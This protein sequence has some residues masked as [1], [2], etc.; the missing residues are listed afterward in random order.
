[1][2]T[3]P[4][5]AGAAPRR[6][7]PGSSREHEIAWRLWPGPWMAGACP[8][9]RCAARPPWPPRPWRSPPPP[10][11]RRRRGGARHHRAPARRHAPP[12]RPLPGLPGYSAGIDPSRL[13]SSG[14][15]QRFPFS[16]GRCREGGLVGRFHRPGGRDARDRGGRPRARRLGVHRVEALLGR[17]ALRHLAEPHRR[18]L[19]GLPRPGGRHRLGLHH[20]GGI[21]ARCSRPAAAPCSSHPATSSGRPS[22]GR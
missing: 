16:D 19:L 15:A 10:A 21:A 5:P 11:G 18:D 1:M 4:A 12:A 8:A 7:P 14:G 17:Q 13:R 9:P 3:Q 20:P 6:C 22:A 2:C